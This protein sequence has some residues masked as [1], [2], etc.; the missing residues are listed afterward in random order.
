[1]SDV[2]GRVIMKYPTH[3]CIWTGKLIAVIKHFESEDI[4]YTINTVTVLSDDIVY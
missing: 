4:Q 1:M 2:T 3:V